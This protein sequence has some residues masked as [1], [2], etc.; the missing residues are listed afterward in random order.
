MLI[1]KTI[2]IA[3]FPNKLK[4]AQVVPSIK[5]TANWR[6]VTIDLSVY[7]Q[8]CRSSS[9]EPYMNNFHIILKIYFILFSS[10]FRPGFGCN[11]A[12]LKIIEEWKKAIDCNQYTA[13]VLMDLSK[14]FDCLPHD[15]LILKLEAY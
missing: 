6:L 1:N 11:T 12:L 14:A 13:A 5:R 3:S 9:R 10:A 2:E 7:Y 15:L 4:E 8:W